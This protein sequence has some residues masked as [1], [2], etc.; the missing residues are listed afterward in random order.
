MQ[1]HDRFSYN[2]RMSEFLAAIGL[3]QVEKINY[4][5]KLRKNSGKKYHKFFP[6]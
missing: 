6:I 2:Y 3:A 5:V 1:R 4:F